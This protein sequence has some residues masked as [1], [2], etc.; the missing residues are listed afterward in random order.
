MRSNKGQ[1][2]AARHN[3]NANSQLNARHVCLTRTLKV[4][5]CA[6]EQNGR[7]NVSRKWRLAKKIDV[8]A[9]KHYHRSIGIETD[10]N[11]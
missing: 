2:E 3:K 8:V 5:G 1:W 6:N 9:P 10:V 7:G 4:S 11:R